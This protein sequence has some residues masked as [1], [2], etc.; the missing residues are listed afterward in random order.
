L[1]VFSFQKKCK[2]A[3]LL[4]HKRRRDVNGIPERP[5]KLALEF[6]FLKYRKRKVPIVKKYIFDYT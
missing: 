3:N 5:R 6:N 4:E 2:Q 1:P